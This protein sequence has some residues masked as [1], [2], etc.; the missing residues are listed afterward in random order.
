VDLGKLF[1]KPVLKNLRDAVA[2]IR[3]IGFFATLFGAAAVLVY[4]PTR[5]FVG[6]EA[7][8]TA[9]IAVAVWGFTLLG[10][11]Y[12][13]THA[14][15][16]DSYEVLAIEQMLV[17]EAVGSH[18]RYSYSKK[19]TIRAIRNDVRLVLFWDHWTGHGVNGVRAE[20][21]IDDH[22]LLDGRQAEE[23][24]RLY[25]WIYP[26]RPIGKGQV[27]EVGIRQVHEDDLVRQ[28]PYH[29]G[30]GLRYR[31]K[32]LT[33]VTR[34]QLAEDPAS[35]EGG[36][37]N[38]HRPVGHNKLVGSATYTRVVDRAAGTVDYIV[39]A[40]NPKRYHSYGVQWQ[41]TQP[42]E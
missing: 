8:V 12:Y 21:L 41:W 20:P 23:D 37:W 7:A 2:T 26:G 35:I 17:I 4:A 5:Q 31:A 14:A 10:F 40:T 33:V 6:P 29:R 15:A 39:T 19:Q 9:G 22:V 16:P 25:R 11:W 24:G 32:H 38:S 27:I 13:R 34:F 42:D 3:A 28:R 1:E 36:V 18:H 30:G